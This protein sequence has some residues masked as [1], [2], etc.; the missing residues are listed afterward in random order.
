[1]KFSALLRLLDIRSGRSRPWCMTIKGNVMVC[2]ECRRQV[3]MPME[4]ESAAKQSLNERVRSYAV[5]ELG[6]RHTENGDF[7]PDHPGAPT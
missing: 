7:C 6:W 1:V 3:S 5:A 4:R 2:D